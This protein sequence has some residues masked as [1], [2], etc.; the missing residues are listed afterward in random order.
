MYTRDSLRFG[1]T[2]DCN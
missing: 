2:Q 1:F